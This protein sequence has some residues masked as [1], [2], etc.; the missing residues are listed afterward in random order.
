MLRQFCSLTCLIA[1][2]V[3]GC[4][5]LSHSMKIPENQRYNWDMIPYV[6]A[7]IRINEPN[8]NA[9]YD[10]TLDTL[11]ASSF[12]AR[13]ILKARQGKSSYLS[14]IPSAESLRQQ[15]VWFVTKPVYVWSLWTAKHIGYAWDKAPAAVNIFSYLLAA[16]ALACMAP[17]AALAG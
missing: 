3:Y 14:L 5:V 1:L 13:S 15:L 9:V 12:H 11:K 16:A 8:P 6:A 7:A 17:S 10:K 2:V 4:V